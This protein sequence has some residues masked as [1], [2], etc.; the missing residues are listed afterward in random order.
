MKKV[1]HELFVNDEKK[2]IFT[3]D[4]NELVYSEIIII[5]GLAHYLL[6]EPGGNNFQSL[7]VLA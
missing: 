7:L 5:T 4:I 2:K 3:F 1:R 6:S